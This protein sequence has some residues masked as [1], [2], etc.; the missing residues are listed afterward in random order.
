MLG[1]I[2]LLDDDFEP[3]KMGCETLA[4][5]WRTF[6]IT[7]TNNIVPPHDAAAPKAGNDNH[8]PA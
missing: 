6:A 4:R 1:Q 2:F 8:D 5:P 7:S 3:L